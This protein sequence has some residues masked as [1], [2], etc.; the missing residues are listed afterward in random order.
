MTDPWPFIPGV[1]YLEAPAQELLEVAALLAADPARR[2]GLVEAGQALLRDRLTMRASLE[3]V[4]A[5]GT[6]T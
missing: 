1:H 5:V 3:Q 4:L 6:R 2:A